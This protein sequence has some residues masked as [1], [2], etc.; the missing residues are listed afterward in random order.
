MAPPSAPISAKSYVDQVK[1]WT[2]HGDLRA[3][4]DAVLIIDATLH[5]PEFQAA[6][7]AKYVDAYKVTPSAL[8]QVSTELAIPATEGFLFHVDTRAHTY[9]VNELK[10]GKS[11]WRISLVA[12]GRELSPLTVTTDRRRPEV[13]QEF[14]PYTT[15]FSQTWRLAF[16]AK[17]AD[18]S[19][20]VTADTKSLVLR[21][22]GP[23]GMIELTWTLK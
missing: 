6:Y 7:V 23:P 21:I 12:D 18:G 22:A 13:Q 17:L 3:D 1:R 15:V 4:F 14:Y 16:P 11:I 5:S 2:R 10:P 9:E 19:D 8:P 20:L